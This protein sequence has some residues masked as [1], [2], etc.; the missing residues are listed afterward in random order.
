MNF[1]V[2]EDHYCFRSAS[3][4]LD[5]YAH[6]YFALV[7][8]FPANTG[9]WYKHRLLP[10]IL[11]G[12]RVSYSDFIA[13]HS[14]VQSA[15]EPRRHSDLPISLEWIATLSIVVIDHWSHNMWDQKNFDSRIYPAL[16]C[17]PG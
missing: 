12:S 1:G 14:A 3:S 2:R 13:K 15:P 7:F 17:W 4:I 5:D 10:F 16:R 9:G 6:F 8:A 11:R